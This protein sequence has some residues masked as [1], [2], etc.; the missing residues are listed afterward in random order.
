MASPWSTSTLS[1]VAWADIL[2][3]ETDVVS[4][5]DAMKVPSIV[6]GRA[7]IVGSLARLPLA[8]WRGAERLEADAWMYRTATDVPPQTRMA[9]TIDDLIFGGASLWA[10]QRGA[11]GQVVDAVRVLPEWW[12]VDPD[13]RILVNGSPVDADE[14]IL[15]TGPQEGL[16]EIAGATIRAAV[17]MERAWASRVVTPAPLVEL[18]GTDAQMPLDEDEVRDLLDAWE[19]ARQ[20]GG[21]TAYTPAQVQAIVHGGSDA[22]LFVEGRNALR[23]DV[24]NFLNLPGELLDGSTATASLT[25]QTSEGSRNELLEYSLTYWAGPV[26]ARLSQDDVCPRGQRVAFDLSHYT[27]PTPPAQAPALED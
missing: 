27:A 19:G 18:H 14:V 15:F 10:V 12:S 17:A 3:L 13:L 2:G 1:R 21:A 4:R 25:Y 11:G 20:S 23:L 6:K 7:L 16:L 24:A 9:Q 26:E 22:S 5:A 8:K